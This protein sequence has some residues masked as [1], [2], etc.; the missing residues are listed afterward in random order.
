MGVAKGTSSLFKKSVF[1]LFNSVGGL[2]ESL[3]NA[4]AHA[5]FDKQ[6]IRERIERRES[7][8]P[9]HI[10]DGRWIDKQLRILPLGTCP[11]LHLLFCCQGH[12]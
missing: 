11:S 7:E 1:G 5:T 6:Y 4:A 9:D 12:S 3:A 8:E 10:L 2:T